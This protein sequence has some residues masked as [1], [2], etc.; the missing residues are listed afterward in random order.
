M[1]VYLLC[2]EVDLRRH[3]AC[4]DCFY[5]VNGGYD[6][7][8][9]Q[10]HFYVRKI[11]NNCISGIFGL[12]WSWMSQTTSSCFIL[13]NSFPVVDSCMSECLESRSC[14]LQCYGA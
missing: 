13:L 6:P 8:A 1:V 4:E 7:K 9:N 3:V 11:I 10:V 2:S 14:S 12:T 5:K